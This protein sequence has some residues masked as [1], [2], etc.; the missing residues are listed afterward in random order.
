MRA[1]RRSRPRARKM[2]RRATALAGA[3]DKR[4]SGRINTVAKAARKT[5]KVGGDPSCLEVDQT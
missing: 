4:K 3:T 5:S 1:I 2:R